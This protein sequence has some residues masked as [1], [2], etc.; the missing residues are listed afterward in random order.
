MNQTKIERIVAGL[1]EHWVPPPPLKLDQWADENIVLPETQ[2]ARPGHYRTWP[3]LREPLD[4]IGAKTPEYVSIIKPSRVGFTKGLMIAVAAIAAADPCSIGLLVPVDEDARD[5]VVDELE[6][7]FA[8]TPALRGLIVS[9]RLTGRNTLT[10]KTFK[11]GATLKILSARAPRRLRR[12]DF[13]V[14]YCDEIDAMEITAE[15]DPIIIAEK[16]TFAHADRKIVRGSTPTE[17][18]VSLIQRAFAESDQRIFEIPCPHCREFFELLWEM[19]QWP[20]GEPE[21]AT[22]FCPRCGAE[23]EEKVKPELVEHGR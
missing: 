12:H 8:A 3:Y 4:S 21:K 17:E 22:A 16:R 7:L 5:Y 11:T 6:P 23:I 19:I 13:K 15:G 20:A 10:R 14:L 1:M 2:N 18:D 9:G